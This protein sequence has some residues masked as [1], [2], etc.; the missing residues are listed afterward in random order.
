[1][2]VTEIANGLN[3]KQPRKSLKK[4]TVVLQGRGKQ[5]FDFSSAD[6]QEDQR[7]GNL[8]NLYAEKSEYAAAG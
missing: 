1:M 2:P 3:W 5:G 7:A 6:M 8:L 4:S